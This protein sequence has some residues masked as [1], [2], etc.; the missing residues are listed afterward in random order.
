MKGLNT[1]TPFLCTTPAPPHHPPKKTLLYEQDPEFCQVY[2]ATP[3]GRHVIISQ[4]GPLRLRLL[5]WQPIGY[6][7]YSENSG[8]QSERAFMRN[9]NSPNIRV[10]CPSSTSIYEAL[11]DQENPLWHLLD[12][13]V[14]D[15][16][17]NLSD[18]FICRSNKNSPLN[19]PKGPHPQGH[20]SFPPPLCALP[21]HTELCRMRMCWLYPIEFKS[22]R[23]FPPQSH[24]SQSRNSINTCWLNKYCASK[25]SLE[26]CLE[27]SHTRPLELRL[28]VQASGLS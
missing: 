28:S 13:D 9:L 14:Q 27:R 11:P 20:V 6:H 25:P 18:R 24:L 2:S 23:S 12:R 5:T 4:S 21:K 8:H 3:T 10:V 17:I 19:P 16:N 1:V 26:D 7:L 22:L 15:Y